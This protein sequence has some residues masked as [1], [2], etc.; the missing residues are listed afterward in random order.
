MFLNYFI[1]RLI[2]HKNNIE[3]EFTTSL[4]YSIQLFFAFFSNIEYVQYILVH[5]QLKIANNKL[6]EFIHPETFLQ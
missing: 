1:A 5:S 3:L 2:S 4:P 6:L